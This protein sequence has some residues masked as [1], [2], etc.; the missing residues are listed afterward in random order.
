[1]RKLLTPVIGL[2]TLMCVTSCNQNEEAELTNETDAITVEQELQNQKRN[3]ATDKALEDAL[4]KDPSLKQRMDLIEQETRK[5]IEKQ[6][7]LPLAQREQVF[8]IPV[9]VHILHR[10]N[11]ENLSN[12]LINSQIQVLNRDFNANNVELRNNRERVPRVFRNRV[13]N[14]GVRFVLD[15]VIRVRTNRVF[16]SNPD[17]SLNQNMKFRNRGGSNPINTREFLNI[18]VC[19][20]DA[21]GFASFPGQNR[22]IDGVVVDT[23]AFGV[24][25]N[26][27]YGL[28]RTTTHEVGHYFNLRHVWGNRGGCGDDDLVG[29]TPNTNGPNYGCPAFPTRNCGS[30]DMTM[31]YMDYTDDACMFMFTNGQRTRMR[32]VFNG[33]RSQLPM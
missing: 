15:R 24:T 9:V 13:A 6:S 17:G 30:A 21:L 26:G 5:F 33:F 14:I 12:N 28:G 31:N 1:M 7:S 32:A 20:T 3:C 22:R 16:N 25:R 2:I 10:N 23:E 29:D 4:L 27:A 19:Q 18:W 8:T 11:A